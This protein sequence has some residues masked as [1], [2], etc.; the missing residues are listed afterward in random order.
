VSAT[1]TSPYPFSRRVLWAAC[2]DSCI[3]R[4]LT[5]LSREDIIAIADRQIVDGA[6][7]SRRAADMAIARLC[8]DGLLKRAATGVYSVTR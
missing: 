6:P 3:E 5:L 8:T 4:G 2:R 1:S 7:L